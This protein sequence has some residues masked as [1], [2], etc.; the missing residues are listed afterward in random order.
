[1]EACLALLVHHGGDLGCCCG[2]RR[3][4]RRDITGSDGRD[5]GELLVPLYKREASELGCDDRE[6]ET[7]IHK[8]D[9][10]GQ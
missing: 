10:E 4:L 1:M 8:R 9:I 7:G 6:Q 3:V 2:Q 5:D